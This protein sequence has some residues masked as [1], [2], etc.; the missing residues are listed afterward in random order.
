M[1]INDKEQ[2]LE[3]T[4]YTLYI[5]REEFN[6]DFLNVIVNVKSITEDHTKLLKCAWAMIKTADE[7]N[8]PSFKEWLKA[9]KN[10]MEVVSLDS[11]NEI[12]RTV[13]NSMKTTVELKKKE[14]VGNE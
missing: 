9:I 5:Y 14:M 3:F 11:M 13:N 6:E 1:K 12:I 2:R 4:G 10:V 8:T 7:E